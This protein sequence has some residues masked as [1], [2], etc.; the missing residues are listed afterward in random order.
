MMNHP[1]LA[2]A[3]FND[4]RLRLETEARTH[5]VL[6]AV[7][8]DERHAAR[9]AAAVIVGLTVQLASRRRFADATSSESSPVNV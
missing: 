4:R 1:P 3:H 8:R 6:R 5:K 9:R 7:R 2:A